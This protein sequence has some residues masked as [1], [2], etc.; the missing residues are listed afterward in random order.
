MKRGLVKKKWGRPRKGDAP[1]RIGDSSKRIGDGR[2]E[3]GIRKKLF[4]DD[5][6]PFSAAKTLSRREQLFQIGRNSS[7]S[8][9]TAEKTKLTERVRNFVCGS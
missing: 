2:A 9:K 3:T 8:R 5:K 1:K 7:N 4:L 6:I